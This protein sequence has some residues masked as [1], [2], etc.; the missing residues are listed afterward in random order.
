MKISNV[1]NTFNHF[2]NSVKI[3]QPRV[4]SVGYSALQELLR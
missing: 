4:W 1:K 3:H 2:L